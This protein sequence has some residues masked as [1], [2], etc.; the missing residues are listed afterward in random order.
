MGQT[1]KYVPAY[2]LPQHLLP[3]G[4]T[5]PQSYREFAESGVSHVGD[6]NYG[7]TILDTVNVESY[8]GYARRVSP[9]IALVPFMRI[10]GHDNLACFDASRFDQESRVYFVKFCEPVRLD[11]GDET[12]A[13]FLASI[14]ADD[15]PDDLE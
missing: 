13:E 14:P 3:P 8:V 7:W 12:F 5:Y 10:Y 15:E 11:G 1:F 2:F 9:N 6:R 4:F